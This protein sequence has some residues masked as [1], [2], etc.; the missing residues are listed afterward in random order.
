MFGQ[1]GEFRHQHIQFSFHLDGQVG[2][3]MRGSQVGSCQPQGCLQLVAV[4]RY[5]LRNFS[6]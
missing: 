4:Q 2:Q 3:W 1:G 6:S 5:L